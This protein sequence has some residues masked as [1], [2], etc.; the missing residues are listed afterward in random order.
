MDAVDANT[1]HSLDPNLFV[2]GSLSQMLR[3]HASRRC[4]TVNQ[5]DRLA[6]RQMENR[7]DWESFV[8][9]RIEAL[10]VSLGD[11]PDPPDDLNVQI[12]GNIEGKGY[13]I[14]NLVF[15][16]RPGVF[17]STN[18]YLPR[19][20][21]ESMPVILLV[22]SHHNPKVQGELQDMGIL[23]ARSGC[24]VLVMDQFGYGDRGFHL[25]GH[26]QD[27]W[28]RSITGVQ[29]HT[30]GD[31]LMGWM[32]WDI[33]RGID[34]LLS[35][36]GAD[37]EKV[38]VMG[39]VAGGGDPAAVAAALDTRISCAVPFNFGGPQ[40]E[41]EYPL[42]ENAEETFNYL[43]SGGWESTRNL[44]LS[45]RDGFLPWVIVGSIAPRHLLYAHEFSWDQDRD[46]VWQRLKTIYNW[47]GVP[48]HLDYALGAGLLKGRPPEATHC[49]NIGAIHRQRIYT[50]LQRWFGI[51]PPEQEVQ[52]R[53]PDEQLQSLTPERKETLEPTHVLLGNLGA[54]RIQ[55]VRK[56]L[57]KSPR[58]SLQEHWANLLGNIEPIGFPSAT[59][60][61]PK[62]FG[63]VRL[64]RL[65]L[66]VEPHILVPMLL[67]R[68]EGSAS[69][70]VALSQ[71]GKAAFL[72]HRA[73]ELAAL[74]DQGIAVCLPDLRGTGETAPEG[75]RHP[76]SSASALSAT[77]WMLGQSLLGARLRDLRCV[78]AYLEHRYPD[79]Q[80]GLWGDAFVSQNPPTLTDPLL[81]S[82]TAPTTSEPLGG[83]LALL[84]GLFEDNIDAILV[85][86]TLAGFQSL[87]D[88]CYCY[89]PHDATVPGALNAG[90]LCDIAATLVPRP[91]RLEG[92]VDGRNCPVTPEAIHRIYEPAR[93]AYADVSHNLC[94][95]PDPK[96]T[97]ASWWANAF[98]TTT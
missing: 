58:K 29:L 15:E 82:D 26:R 24:L 44:R 72:Q 19:P 85:R 48:D 78:L 16:S 53:H 79:S 8:Q 34:L 69:T 5:Q 94:L 27:Y 38:I 6:W 12:S 28:F 77:E 32:V 41:T 46:P 59:P 55:A 66:T 18:L 64:E 30:I 43:G 40:P 1:L 47:Y 23:W 11:F 57:S 86:N 39:S 92:L 71:S 33:S 96:N 14:E 45:G 91:L 75:L 36:K 56:N 60:C 68:P 74:L 76:R 50:A 21:Q 4:Q 63:P 90:D 42:P 61:K 49:N 13:R 54:K 95:T 83:L 87:F 80:F 37:P 25:P 70:I 10:R 2:D 20:L 84:G 81:E 3:D 93:N 97:L 98:D 9:P 88:D 67:F 89:I 62:Q 7:V 51:A 17:V 65:V 73:D 22:H 35:Q 52:E 31:S